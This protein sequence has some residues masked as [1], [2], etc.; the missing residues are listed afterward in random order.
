MESAQ[1]LIEIDK[2]KPKIPNLEKRGVTV[3]DEGLVADVA[4]VEH[5]ACWI[6]FGQRQGRSERTLGRVV[7]HTGQK[8][9][10]ECL[11]HLNGSG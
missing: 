9:L 2:I 10:A 8:I 11:P 1:I 4:L 7:D 3:P 6:V 5:E